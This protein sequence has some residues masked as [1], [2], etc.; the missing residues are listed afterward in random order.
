[1]V[2]QNLQLQLELE[3]DPQVIERQKKYNIEN[4]EEYVGLIETP[5]WNLM[6]DK[7]VLKINER[8]TRHKSFLPQEVVRHEIWTGGI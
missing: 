2:T 6:W 1:M 8:P 5:Y 4:G 3:A 7:R